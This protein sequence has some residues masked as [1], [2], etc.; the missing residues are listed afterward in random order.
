MEL[1]IQADLFAGTMK[2]F[3]VKTRALTER[4]L[5]QGRNVNRKWSWI[6]IPISKLILI[7]IQVFVGSLAQCCGFTAT[8][9]SVISPSFVKKNCGWLCEKWWGI[10]KI[11]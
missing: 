11:L 10:S 4:K 6:R 1:K 2:H 3:T 5:H 9:A 7:W 8:S